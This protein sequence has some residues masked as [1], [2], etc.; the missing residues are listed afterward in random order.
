MTDALTAHQASVADR[1]LDEESA[2]RRHLVVHL[3]GAHAY[4]FASPDSDLDLKAIHVVPTTSL[5]GLQSPALVAN[6][7]E[8]IDDVEIDYTSNE[9]AVAIRG[10]IKGDGNMLE[11]VT[12]ASP[13]RRSPELDEL[14]RLGLA[15]LSQRYYRHYRGFASSQRAAVVEASPPKAKKVLYVLRTV[16]TGV[17][18]LET[19]ECIPDLTALCDRYGFEQSHELITFKRAAESGTLPVDVAESVPS[20][21]DRAFARLDEALSRTPLPPDP[22]PK[23]ESDLEAWLVALRTQALS[24]E[25][26]IRSPPSTEGQYG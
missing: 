12:S 20:L 18:L 14:R 4:G 25:P 16:L 23:S 9:I 10:L 13:L 7:L 5:L 3:S 15:A 21:L 24:N 17:H 2:A 1:V 26:P 11:R 22:S 6:R 8:V 19:G